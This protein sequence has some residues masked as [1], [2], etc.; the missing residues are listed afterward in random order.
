M[1][2]PTLRFK[3]DA[4]RNYPEWKVEKIIHVSDQINVGF[5]GSCEYYAAFDFIE[6][7]F[8]A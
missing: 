5:V 2:V 1:T 4:G 7:V 3:V 8:S 6:R